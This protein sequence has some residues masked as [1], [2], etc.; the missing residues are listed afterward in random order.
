M[1]KQ[2]EN[3]YM[4]DRIANVNRSICQLVTEPFQQSMYL[5]LW[6]EGLDPPHTDTQRYYQIVC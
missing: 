4:K 6:K 2:L 5:A 1:I 3:E